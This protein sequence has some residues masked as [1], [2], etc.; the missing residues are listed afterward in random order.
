MDQWGAAAP[1]VGGTTA[2]PSWRVGQWRLILLLCVVGGGGGWEEYCSASSTLVKQQKQIGTQNCRSC[3]TK[4]CRTWY[5]ISASTSSTVFGAL[6][7][8]QDETKS[9]RLQCTNVNII[10]INHPEFKLVYHT[11]HGFW[12]KQEPEKEIW[13]AYMTVILIQPLARAAAIEQHNHSIVVIQA[14]YAWE[15]QPTTRPGINWAPAAH[16]A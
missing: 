13:G 2:L 11:K 15:P 6:C 10:L 7:P 8:T 3:Y 12:H 16:P 9:V 4:N 1:W 5:W 14:S